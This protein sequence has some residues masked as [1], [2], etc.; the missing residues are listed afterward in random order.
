[1]STVTTESIITN[2]RG[3]IKDVLQTDGRNVFTYDSD[4]TFKLSSPNIAS[5]GM[6]VYLNG[7]ALDEGDWDYNSDTNRVTITPVTSGVSLT[8]GDNIIVTFNYYRKYSD[9]EIQDYIRANLTQFTIYRYCKSFYM[10]DSDEVVTRNGENPTSDEG[11]IIAII[12]AVDIDPQNVD[13]RTSDFSLTSSETMS[14]RN[15][16]QE[17][18]TTWLRTFGNIDFLDEDRIN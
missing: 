4:S 13:I 15:Q 17:I 6:I 12:T 1:M 2:I 7:V 16:I 9:A 3:H 10:N 14:K 8:K 5:T 11:N 18:F